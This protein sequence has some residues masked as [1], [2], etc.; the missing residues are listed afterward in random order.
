MRLPRGK[1]ERDLRDRTYRSQLLIVEGGE[2]YRVQWVSPLFSLP[3]SVPEGR[4]TTIQYVQSALVLQGN[5][6]TVLL[7]ID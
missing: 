7:K 6:F 5:Q 1:A 3:P 4:N 2:P